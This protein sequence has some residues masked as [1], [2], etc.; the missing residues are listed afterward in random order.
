VYVRRR[1]AAREV[2]TAIGRQPSWITGYKLRENHANLD[3]SVALM[4][5]IGWT[6]EDV[7]SSE[8]IDEEALTLLAQI[9]DLGEEDRALVVEFVER[10]SGGA[11]VFVASRSRGQQTPARRPVTRRVAG[12]G[13]DG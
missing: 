8:P 13:R 3:T 10:V 4:R 11:V 5:A 12:K 1:G 6:P 2:A 9:R 7:L